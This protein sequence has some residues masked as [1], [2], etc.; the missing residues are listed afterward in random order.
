M[1]KRFTAALKTVGLKKFLKYAF[2]VKHEELLIEGDFS[3]LKEIS[4]K[5]T[6]HLLHIEKGQQAE[7]LEYYMQ[8]D[9]NELYNKS[10]ISRYFTSGFKCFIALKKGKFT[11]HLW[12]A[13]NKVNFKHSDPALR[14]IGETFELLDGDA[15]AVDFFIIPN[16]RGGGTALEFLAKAYVILTEQGYKRCFGLVQTQNKGA[17]WTYK[18]M[19]HVESKKL[20]VHRVFNYLVLIGK[21]LYL[22]PHSLS[23]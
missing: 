15:L 5:D 13:D 17:R 22:S 23:S 3:K 10:R 16:E 6:L 21:K 4:Y 8:S 20:I 18:I 12:L 1:S 7:L 19:G 11:G 14:Y 2:Y 9:S